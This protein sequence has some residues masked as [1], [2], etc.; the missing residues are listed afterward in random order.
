MSRRSKKC[1]L[2]ATDWLPSEVIYWLN[3]PSFPPVWSRLSKNNGANV[4]RC[5]PESKCGVYDIEIPKELWSLWGYLHPTNPVF[6]PKPCDKLSWACNILACCAA[7]LY[8]LAQWTPRLLDTIVISGDRY[9][10][11]SLRKF[12]GET[13]KFT[14]NDLCDACLLEN[15]RFKVH[16]EMVLFGAL[17]ERDT[18]S[19]MNLSKALINFFSQH[20][21]GLLHCRHLRALVIGRDNCNGCVGGDYFMFDCQSKDYPLFREGDCRPYL[22]RC[23]TLQM[24]L[25]CIV[26]ALEVR[27]KRVQFA[28][29]KVD[30]RYE[31]PVPD[32][33][34]DEIKKLQRIIA[35]SKEKPV[36]AGI[37]RI[38][39]ICRS[40]QCPKK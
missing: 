30:I 23:K 21:M 8:T 35:R 18:S 19:I 7:K 3:V 15:L 14:L 13:Y 26:M 39:N 10:R 37:S 1:C 27:C 11:D 9:Y 25:Y 4:L 29:H 16:T 32:E 31:G 34:D 36:K 33:D 28:L 20:K 12:Q 22:L 2:D 24:L 38:C 40:V 6:H 17:Y 5:T